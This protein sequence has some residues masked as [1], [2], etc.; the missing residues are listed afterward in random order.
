MSIAERS[1]TSD[2]RVVYGLLATSALKELDQPRN[3]S[4][5]VYLVNLIRLLDMYR[6]GKFSGRRPH[7]VLESKPLR[8]YSFVRQNRGEK[9]VRNA[10]DQA[11]TFACPGADTESFVAHTRETLLSLAQGDST[12]VDTESIDILKRFITKLAEELRD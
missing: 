4:R 1:R 11:R 3:S 12:S 8:Q 6:H 5:D 10:L 7:G 2:L 9:D